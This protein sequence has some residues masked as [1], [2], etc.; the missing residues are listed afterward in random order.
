VDALVIAPVLLRLALLLVPSAQRERA[1]EEWAADLAGCAEAGLAPSA[2]A[3]GALR[4]AAV[5]RGDAALR[6]LRR[7]RPVLVGLLLGAACALGDVSVLVVVLVAGGF[8][9]PLLLRSE[10]VRR[11]TAAR[12]RL[13]H[14]D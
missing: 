7:V 13:R 6:S 4:A 3:A 2:V 11:A 5:A 1:G 9:L 14:V 10:W 8:Q 12:S